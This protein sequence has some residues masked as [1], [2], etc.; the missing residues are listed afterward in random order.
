M[1]DKRNFS[2]DKLTIITP[3]FND[4][5]CLTRLS[6]ELRDALAFVRQKS[7]VIV[8][9]GSISAY[10]K[11]VS[12]EVLNSYESVKVINLGCNVGHQ[13]AIAIGLSHTVSENQLGMVL[14]ID[15]D[16]EDMPVD[17]GI[18]VK[19]L[20][21]NK[22]SIVVS[23][24]SKRSEN[25]RF[26]ASYLIYKTIFIMLTG[27]KIDFGNFSAFYMQSAS[28]LAYMPDLWN[29]FPATILKSR[30]PIIK[31]STT[32]GHRFEGYSRM[33]FIALVNHGLASISVLI[34]IAFARMLLFAIV[35]AF[36]LLITGVAIVLIKAF[37][38]YAIPG[39]ATMG[40]GL[41]SIGLLQI[42]VLVSLVSFLALSARS[43]FNRPT[44]R[45]ALDYIS[46]V[47]DLKP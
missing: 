9:D 16:G 7:L 45:T 34:D 28:R 47:Q 20:L 19:T 26:K 27:K 40:T 46:S 12:N 3:V 14:V 11:H 1:P 15:S 17:A 24:R 25:K 30:L 44:I 13:R 37:T 8:N 32:R 35:I 23:K 18:L 33:N 43:N 36:C 10:D 38:P 6:L 2:C 4:W 29:H 42:L 21:E 22:E 31:V 39:W 41:V 5:R